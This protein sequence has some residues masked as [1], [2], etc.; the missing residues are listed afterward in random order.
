[1]SIQRTI[2]TAKAA[3]ASINPV[4]IL[5]LLTAILFTIAALAGCSTPSDSKDAAG[6][7]SSR[8]VNLYTDRHYDTDDEIYNAFTEETGIKVNVIKGKSDELIERLKTEGEDTEA[9]LF[10]T[11]DA[12]RLHRVSGITSRAEKTAPKAIHISAEP[13]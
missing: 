9:D 8:V 11:A 4:K 2:K 3:K 13:L 10:I 12:G 6:D 1:M 7:N 5:S